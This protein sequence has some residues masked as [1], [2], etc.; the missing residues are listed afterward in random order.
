[1]SSVAVLNFSASA[2]QV[3]KQVQDIKAAISGG[4]LS[5]YLTGGPAVNSELTKPVLRGP[6]QGGDLRS[7]RGPHR[8]H[9][10]VRQSCVRGAAGGHRRAGRDGHPGRPLPARPRDEHVHLRDEHGDAPG[11]CC[12]HRLRSL[13]GV[14]LPRG[15][16][17]GRDGPGGS[18]GDGGPRRALR[19]L[20][21][22]G[23]GGR[24]SG[25][26]VLPHARPALGGH[27]R[28]VGGVLLGDRL[29]HLPARPAR[30]ARAPGRPAAG[31]P[32]ARGPRRQ[33]LAP[34]GQPGG[35]TALCRHHRG[36][37]HHRPARLA[38]RHHEDPDERRHHATHVR[39]IAAGSRNSSTRSTTAPPSRRSRCCSPGMATARSICCARPL[40]SPTA[41]S[42]S[43][44][45]G[46]PPCS[47]RSP[48]RGWAAMPRP[49]SPSG[50]S[51]NNC[52]TT[53]TTSSSRPTASP[54]AGPPSPL[55]N[56][57]SSNSW[58]SRR[59]RPT[60]SSSR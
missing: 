36:G 41:S 58:S 54:S 4:P 12:G 22:P 60:P 18:G 56:S 17:Q 45:R 7:A 20:Q 53:R 23:G 11:A 51:S 31:D 44:R 19:L 35:Q 55:P 2:Q 47:A 27:R 21:R 46:W 15:T 30:R 40:S 34:L 38:R 16:P 57:S 52:S 59:W 13:H 3:Q 25:A 43:R 9:L 5:T 26:G 42:S 10:R 1:M 14:A 29:A 24:G 49:W 39:G 37:D 28:R 50:R 8:A 33:A 6:P 48:S 32:A